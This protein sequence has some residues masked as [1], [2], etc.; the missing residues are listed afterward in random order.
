MGP[1]IDAVIRDAPCDVTIAKGDEWKGAKRILVPTAGGPNAPIAARLAWLVS[2]VYGS[3]VTALYVQLGRATPQRMEENRRLIANTL[4]GLEFSRPVEQKVVVADS[5]VSGIVREAKDYDLV[6]L[7][8]SEE[9]LFDQFAFGS[10]PQQIAARVP[11]TAVMVKHYG[12]PTELWTRRLARGLF[13]MLPRLN[14]EEQLE[15]REAMRDSARPGVNYF[16]LIVLSGIIATLG[17]LLDSAAVVIGAMLVA[18]LMSPIM[19]F[20][21]GMVLGDVRLIR[22]SVE[23]VFKGVALAVVIA[24]FTGILS[25][26]K[27]LTDEIMAR[28]QPT[29]LDLVVALASGMA[30]AYALARQEVGAALPGVA[31]A[32]ALM[33]PLGVVGLGLALGEP[34]VVGGA[35]LLFVTNIAAISLAGVLVFIVLGVRPQTWRPE[36]RRR[37][38][39]GLF[40]FAFLLLVIAIPLGVIMGGI[41][42][43]TARH[44][45]IQEVLQEQMTAQGRELVDLEHRTEQGRLLVVATVRSVDQ[46]EEPVVDSIAGALRGRLERPV[47]LEVV[48]L[49]V[50]RSSD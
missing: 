28:T 5:V 20:S 40:G 15:L 45:T 3:Q 4:R 44:H 12:G 10:I 9:G 23:A 21:L 19:G 47:T 13:R 26:F 18:P 50:V 27:G 1:V 16:V 42:R 48:T 6:L 17:L 37:M 7:G 29:L 24:V 2:E 34:Q 39:R 30:G 38:R 22:L 8:A 31:I 11:R 43:D 36:T 32:A 33:P 46:L 41:V 49:P 35:F 25:P 14:V